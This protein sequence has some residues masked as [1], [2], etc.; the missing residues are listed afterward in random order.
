MGPCNSVCLNTKEKDL[1]YLDDLNNYSNKTNG[2]A[3]PIH[4]H[5]IKSVKQG[6]T[7][8]KIEEEFFNEPVQLILKKKGT[9]ISEMRGNLVLQRDI[10]IDGSLL[11]GKASGNINENYKRLKKLGEGSYGTVYLVNHIYS[12]Q[13]RAM[14]IITKK[15]TGEE[16]QKVDLEIINEID[17]LKKMDHPNIVKIFEFY[18]ST[19]NYYLITEFCKQGELFDK[20]VKE[21]PFSEEFS[22]YVMYQ[23]FSAVFYCHSMNI[24][25]RDLKPENILIEREEKHGIKI[26]IIDFG[27]AKIFEK[28][29]VERK[30]I[31]SSYYIA[32]EVLSKSYNEKC[33]LWSC[34]VIMYILLSASPPFSGRNDNEIIENIKKGYYDFESST[35]QK[36]SNE[37]KHLIKNLLERN[38]G[39]RISAEEA[40]E[41]KWFKMLKTKEK[42][43]FL[44]PEKIKKMLYQLRRYSPNKILQH[45]ALA[46]LVHNFP[47]HEEVRDAFKL[48]SII[49]VNSN[50]KIT[51]MELKTGIGIFLVGENQKDFDLEKLIDEIF[52]TI[53]GD[54]NGYIEYEEFVRGSINKENFITEE[55][56]KFSFLFFDKDQNGEITTEEIKEI[57]LK[58]FNKD[59]KS[60]ENSI[61]SM[62]IEVD[63]NKDGKIS[64]EE[65]KRMMNSLLN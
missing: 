18:N 41:H 32:P 35:W 23:I 13:N 56:I 57:L 64:Y 25:H 39:I 21:G 54:N 30:I 62:I 48:F 37:A 15:N 52:S 63:V 4:S 49:D 58:N 14:K 45:I 36:V 17:I 60:Q 27:T 53:D 26:K 47:Q 3:K 7:N 5:H 43:N 46:Y 8:E 42:I 19:K 6:G 50:G 10:I 20:I 12:G 16:N 33:D 22:S 9:L 28:N 61:R 59:V 1:D 38:V 44:E 51:K 24:L 29:K 31:G 65:F 55:I 40:L 34:G 2:Q 11:V